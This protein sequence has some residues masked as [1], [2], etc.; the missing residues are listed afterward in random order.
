MRI[1]KH[2]RRTA[3]GLRSILA[4]GA[5]VVAFAGGSTALAQGGPPVRW[6]RDGEHYYDA[7]RHRYDAEEGGKHDDHGRRH[8]PAYG[9]SPYGQT[10]PYGGYAPSYGTNGRTRYGSTR[11]GRQHRHDPATRYSPTY[12]QQY[13]GPGSRVPAQRGS[14]GHHYYDAAGHRYDAKD[15][16]KHDDHG[17]RHVPRY[18]YSPY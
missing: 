18:G 17:R 11:Y 8:V 5:L 6:E 12:P 16:G 3:L 2:R 1:E 9:Y 14:D 15:G 10:S 4:A 7:S 13:Y